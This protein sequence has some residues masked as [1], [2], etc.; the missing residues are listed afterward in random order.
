MLCKRCQQQRMKDFCS[1]QHPIL[2]S[3]KG[4]PYKVKSCFMFLQKTMKMAKHPTA[5]AG[6]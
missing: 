2:T 5:L 4:W 6:K 3:T 1:V